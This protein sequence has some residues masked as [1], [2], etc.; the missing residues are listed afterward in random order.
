MGNDNDA[1]QSPA[2]EPTPAVTPAPTASPASAPVVP[3]P[4]PLDPRWIGLVKKGDDRPKRELK[5]HAPKK[6]E[7]KERNG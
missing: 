2:P 6:Q 5:E 3:P 1:K 7:I 4:P